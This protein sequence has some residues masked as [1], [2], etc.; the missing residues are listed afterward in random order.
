MGAKVLTTIATV[1]NIE[2]TVLH[3]TKGSNEAQWRT[4]LATTKDNDPA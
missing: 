2:R 1:E 4:M 3:E